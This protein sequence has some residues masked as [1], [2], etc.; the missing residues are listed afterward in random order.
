MT[1][2][3]SEDEVERA[4]DYLRDDAGPAAQ[5]KADRIYVEEFRKVMKAQIMKEHDEKPLGAQE[6]EAYADERYI[7][8]LDAIRDAVAADERHRFLREAA[9][10]KINA[11][12]TQSANER[13]MKL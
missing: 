7:A 6:R 4:L 12:Q 5:A 8:H 13:A 10:A 11:W 9:S 2:F 1:S 3:I